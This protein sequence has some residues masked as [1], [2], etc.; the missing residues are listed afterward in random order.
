MKLIPKPDMTDEAF[1]H[2]FTTLA[3]NAPE[4]AARAALTW[5]NRYFKLADAY[6]KRLSNTD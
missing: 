2:T 5:R 6:K 3:R 1:L 4:E